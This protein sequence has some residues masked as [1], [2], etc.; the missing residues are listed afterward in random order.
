MRSRVALLL[1]VS[2]SPARSWAETA[3]PAGVLPVVGSTARVLNPS[4]G[5]A[6]A[7]KGLQAVLGPVEVQARL[8]AD[9]EVVRRLEMARDAIALAREHELQMNRA[10]ATRA[11]AEAIHQLEEMR[12]PFHVPELA[13]KAYAALALTY[14]LR[15]T[16]LRAAQGAFRQA[17]AVDPDYKPASGQIPPQAA[18]ILERERKTLPLVRRPTPTDL[19]WLAARL[20]LPRIVWLHVD[21]GGVAKI[22]VY[23]RGD[24]S[25]VSTTGKVAVANSLSEAAAL[26]RD[27]LGGVPEKPRPKPPGPRRGPTGTPWYRRW[28]VWTIA[29]VVVA[30]AAVG[31]GV[32]LTRDEPSSRYDFHFH[33]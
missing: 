2:L 14:L 33:F 1:L 10:A 32:A 31:V 8:A 13:A 11:A 21:R 15:P 17:L 3:R 5:R 30:G 9:P 22:V 26:I 28:W 27:R 24:P 18:E 7:E 12:A 16:D 23:T 20:K 29:G 6:V 19:A 25:P 4:L